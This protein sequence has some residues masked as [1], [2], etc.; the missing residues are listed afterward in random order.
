MWVQNANFT[1]ISQSSSG[2]AT[3]STKSIIA[4][5]SGATINT[6]GSNTVV[7]TNS[8]TVTNHPILALGSGDYTN[9]PVFSNSVP[10]VF[11]NGTSNITV[12]V[13]RTGTNPP[14]FTFPN[15]AIT[16]SS[17]QTVNVFT[18]GGLPTGTLTAVLVTNGGGSTVFTVTGVSSSTSGTNG[19]I[20]LPTFAKNAK[21]IVKTPSPS[22]TNGL[23]GADG[24]FVRE[25]SAKTHTDTDVSSLFGVTPNLIIP[26]AKGNGFAEDYG[27]TFNGNTITFDCRGAGTGGIGAVKGNSQRK[28]FNSTLVGSG[29]NN[30]APIVITGKLNLTGGAVE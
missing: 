29:A 17:T 12:L 8:V 13:T 7:T 28:N 6:S 1:L 11:T 21:L 27:I 19:T 26:N 25:G 15:T 2:K 18:N 5:L 4:A 16:S 24:W 22:G 23:S 3:L 20:T 9:T 30:A 10:V 14:T